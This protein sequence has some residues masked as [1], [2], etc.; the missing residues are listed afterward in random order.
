MPDAR[1]IERYFERA[2]DALAGLTNQIAR[3]A[4]AVELVVLQNFNVGEIQKLSTCKTCG[5][6]LLGPPNSTMTPGTT[7][8]ACR[9]ERDDA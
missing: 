7:C 4:S 6:R 3:L 9:T 2:M 1:E 8:P 5:Y